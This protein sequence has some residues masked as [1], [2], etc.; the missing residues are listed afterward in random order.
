MVLISR[1]QY[2]IFSFIFS[3]I[4]SQVL[5]TKVQPSLFTNLVGGQYY[6]GNTNGGT[7]VAKHAVLVVLLR[8]PKSQILPIKQGGRG[9]LSDIGGITPY[10]PP[11]WA[12][13]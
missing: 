10:R 3:F 7:I 11:V 13:L 1:L 12:P 9:E 6:S 4:F 8:W 5:N 2:I